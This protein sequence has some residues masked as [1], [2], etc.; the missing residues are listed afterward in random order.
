MFLILF[1]K[2]KSGNKFTREM[3]CRRLLFLS[4]WNVGVRS[5]FGGS[6]DGIVFWVLGSAIALGDVGS[7]SAFWGCGNAIAVWDVGVRSL[8][9]G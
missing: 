5:L 1:I 3:G 6:G 2:Q 9:G 4:V 7:A 8:F